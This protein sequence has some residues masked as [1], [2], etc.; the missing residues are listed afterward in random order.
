M[1]DTDKLKA[2]GGLNLSNMPDW[3][4]IAIFLLGTAFAGGSGVSIAGTDYSGD[5]EKLN[6]QL[7]EIRKEYSDVKER[8]IT[9]E[10]EMK[11][12]KKAK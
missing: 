7:V 12:L 1:A 2:G 8:V 10:V 11:N 3:V 6:V 9:L 5:F 4:K